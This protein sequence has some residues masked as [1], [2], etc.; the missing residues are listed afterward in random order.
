MTTNGK[1][2]VTYVE[3]SLSEGVSVPPFSLLAV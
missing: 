3:L 1:Y 2:W